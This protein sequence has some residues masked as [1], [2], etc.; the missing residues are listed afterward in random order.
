M[1]DIG[2]L[3]LTSLVAG[4]PKTLFSSLS[5]TTEHQPGNYKLCFKVARLH[6]EGTDRVLKRPAGEWARRQT[7]VD[8]SCICKLQTT[9]GGCLFLLCW[10]EARLGKAEKRT[11]AYIFSKCLCLPP[12]LCL[13]SSLYCWEI[14]RSYITK[15]KDRE[16]EGGSGRE[17]ER[18]TQRAEKCTQRNNSKENGDGDQQLKIS[19]SVL[20]RYMYN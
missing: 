7:A 5:Q 14:L 2:S 4:L 10:G 20:D 19:R 8:M 15:F 3:P 1:Q 6:A 16:R 13:S 18:A 9:L 12:S 17:T 11:S